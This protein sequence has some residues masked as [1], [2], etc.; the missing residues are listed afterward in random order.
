M[1]NYRAMPRKLIAL[2][3]A[4]LA[5]LLPSCG[6]KSEAENAEDDRLT[7]REQKR[8]RA[9][10]IYKTFAREYFD[11]PRAEEASKRAAALEAAAPKK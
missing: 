3:I 2:A 5:L 8:K 7:I 4:C 9:I 10:E 1:T 6:E 11:D